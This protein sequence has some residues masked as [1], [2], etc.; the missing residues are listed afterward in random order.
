MESNKMLE[1]FNTIQEELGCNTEVSIDNLSNIVDKVLESVKYFQTQLPNCD[2]AFKLIENA[3][4]LSKSNLQKYY[5]LFIETSSKDAVFMAFVDDVSNAVDID[6][7]ALSQF[8]HIIAYFRK[9]YDTMPN[10]IR[11]EISGVFDRIEVC[12][13]LIENAE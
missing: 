1:M 8:K 3:F 9:L 2:D 10:R 4:L 13:F 11:N 7:E 12:I 6:M 5:T